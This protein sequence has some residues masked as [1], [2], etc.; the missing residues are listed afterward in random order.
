MTSLWFL[1]RP[2]RQY[3]LR[4]MVIFSGSLSCWAGASI[5]DRLAFPAGLGLALTAYLFHEWAH[6]FAAQ[7]ASA[8]F[9]PAT[10]WYALFLFNLSSEETPRESFLEISL[11]G[12]VA[13]LIYMVVFLSLPASL[14]SETAL[15]LARCLATLTLIFEAPI[16]LWAIIKNEVPSVGIPGFD[17]FN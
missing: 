5:D 3:A 10:R 8:A 12:F 15:T 16:V 14:S 13:T 6:L 11:A 7:R 1:N 4:D 9:K 2:W 17:T